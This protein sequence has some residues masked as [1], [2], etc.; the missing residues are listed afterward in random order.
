MKLPGRGLLQGLRRHVGLASLADPGFAFLFD[1]G[2]AG[3]VVSLDCET[4]G[5]DIRRDQVISVAAVMVRGQR[6]ITSGRFEAVVRPDLMPREDS[7]KV[8]QLRASDV[9]AGRPMEEVL[10]GLL[11]FIG[12]RPLL[13]YYI[14]FDIAMLDRHVR[15]MLRVGLPNQRIELSGLYYERKYGDAPPGT[16]LDLRFAAM[17]R[18]LGIPDLGQHD[19]GRDAV[20]VA[21]MYL[22]LLDLARRRVRIPRTSSRIAETAPIGA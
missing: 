16:V 18:D 15:A 12:G 11:R 14:D 10:P 1:P 4:T 6:I 19:A 22:Q 5:L 8:H 9:A 20:M 3:E 17:L 21:M 2:P 13:G 7:I